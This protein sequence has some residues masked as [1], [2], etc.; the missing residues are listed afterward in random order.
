MGACIRTPDKLPYNT[1]LNIE[2]VTADKIANA[3]NSNP[4]GGTPKPNIDWRVCT[5]VKNATINPT[6]MLA[7]DVN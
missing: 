4:H 7:C 6:I 1:S 2:Y 5:N 3:K